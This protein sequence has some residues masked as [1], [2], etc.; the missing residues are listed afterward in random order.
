VLFLCELPSDVERSYRVFIQEVPQ[1]QSIRSG[2]V[3]TLL[4]ISVPIFVPPANSVLRLHWQ[5]RAAHDGKIALELRNEG[6]VHVQVTSVAL[7]RSNGQALAREKLSVYALP[8][9]W[10]S[11]TLT[12]PASLVP[13][14]KV[15]LSAQTD[16]GNVAADIAVEP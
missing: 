3:L 15:H 8:G 2:E 9:Q 5:A 4:R 6:T 1:D 10:Q 12:S 13:G 7:S 11:W 16:Q 14:E